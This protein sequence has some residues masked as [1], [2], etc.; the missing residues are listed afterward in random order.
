MTYPH[1]F[2][3]PSDLS[4]RVKLKELVTHPYIKADIGLSFDGD[5]DRLGVVD[6]NG[7]DIWSDLILA[8]LAEQLLQKSPG[9]KIVYDVKC[10]QAVEDVIRQGGG[11]PVM[12][13]TGHSYI[14]AK[15]RETGAALAGERSG[16]IFFGG[17]EYYGFDDAMFAAAKLVEVLSHQKKSVSALLKEFPQYVTSPEL[18]AHCPD[19]EK[20]AV[21]E[22]IVRVLKERFPGRVNDV[23]GARVS[24]EHGWGLVR[25]SSNMPELVL[26]FEADT[27]AHMRE[28][29]GVFAEIIE[30]HESVEK[31]W[32]LGL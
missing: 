21:T 1:Y 11:E 28:I 30:K 22:A 12:W 32:D 16:H 14:K 25:A 8:V 24:F 23:N 9:E 6:E 10:S 15:M 5:G 2:P 13:K 7:A 3:N 29:A 26:V 17:G 19:S 20:Y 4:T 27:D 31:G 18:K